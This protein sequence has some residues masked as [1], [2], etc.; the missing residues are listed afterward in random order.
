M[1]PPPMTHFRTLFRRNFLSL[2]I[3]IDFYPPF[4]HAFHFSLLFS[5][6]EESGDTI[7]MVI[8]LHGCA[9]DYETQRYPRGADKTRRFFTQAKG[10]DVQRDRYATKTPESLGYHRVRKVCQNLILY[11]MSQKTPDWNIGWLETEIGRRKYLEIS[12]I[13]TIGDR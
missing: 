9:S 13:T 8:T 7:S 11:I 2:D 3:G 12:F 4:P 1:K 5:L 6:I 10:W